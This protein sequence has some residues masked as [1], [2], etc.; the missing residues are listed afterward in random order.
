M[1][2]PTVRPLAAAV[3]ANLED[4]ADALPPSVRQRDE[5]NARELAMVQSVAAKKRA[6][7]PAEGGTPRPLPDPLP[8][9]QA[10][11]AAMLPD[12]LRGWCTDA[13]EGLGV[14]LDFLAVPAIVACAAAIGRVV[15]VRPKVQDRWI[16]RAILWGAVIGRP[17]AGKSPALAPA[18]RMLERLELAE[19]KAHAARVAD[20]LEEQFVQDLQAKAAKKDAQKAVEDGDTETARKLAK[21]ATKAQQE[22]PPE[23]RI[24]VSD[25]TIEKLGDLLNENPRGLLMVRDELTGWLASLDREGH[26]SDRAFWLEC[27]NGTGPFVT[28]R[29]GRGTIRIEACAVSLLG[30]IQP[31]K[32]AE[33][34]R[35]AV[36]G[37]MGDDGLMQRFQLAVYPDLAASWSYRDRAPSPADELRA[38][39]TFERLRGLTPASVG[40]TVEEGFDLP[41]LP[42]AD[43]AR[44]LWIEWQNDLMPRLRSGA[45]PAHMESHLAKFPALACRLALVLHLIDATNGPVT[46]DA[47]AKALDWCTYLESHA[48]RI[49]AP[50]ADGGLSAA[51]ALLRK[52][53]ELPDVFT[54]RDVYRKCWGGLDADT[55]ADALAVLVEYHHLIELAP[56][57]TS[58]R[59]TMRYGWRVPA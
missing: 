44:Q 53:K 37:G 1:N 38:W 34:V 26:G 51:H 29:I 46:G 11:D 48:R 19:R 56:E 40:A 16:E 25:S 35:G 24:V 36:K 42:L 10:F 17:S 50:L 30:G 8:S 4:R 15:A 21:N 5:R 2:A 6:A 28:D 14:P 33:Y 39:R 3:R 18:R 41:W 45:E 59:P 55:T 22:T 23:P 20:M 31:G 9:V 58:G 54:T 49:Y 13:A 32:L 47:M 52:R 12:A 43:D 27:W 7:R 57:Q